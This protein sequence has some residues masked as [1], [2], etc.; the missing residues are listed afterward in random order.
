MTKLSTYLKES[1]LSKVFRHNEKH[2][3][4]ALT[5]FRKARDCGDG[6][7][8]TKAENKKRNISLETKLQSIG[9]DII[10]VGGKIKK[11]RKCF[12]CGCHR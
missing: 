12:C 8:Y 5:A 11:R 7:V 10:K 3:C 2:D 1:S 6:I 9:Y 4:G